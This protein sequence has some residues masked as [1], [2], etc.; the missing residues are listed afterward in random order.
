MDVPILLCSR[1]N[2]A[3]TKRPVSIWGTAVTL[4]GIKRIAGQVA[5][6]RLRRLAV[7]P[8]D[9]LLIGEFKLTW[10]VADGGTQAPEIVE[11]FKSSRTYSS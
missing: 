9:E 2:E 6:Q 10:S 11:S 8:F 7:D 5:G 3:L 1:R 4:N